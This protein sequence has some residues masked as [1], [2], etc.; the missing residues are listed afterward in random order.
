[1][2]RR[3]FS[4]T[5]LMGGSGLLL[6]GRSVSAAPQPL[7]LAVAS[8]T[9]E[10]NGRAATVFGLTGPD[11]RPGLTLAASETVEVDLE[12][13]LSEE[14]M[15]HWHGLL[16]AW[17]QDGVPDM[18][19]PLLKA[20]ET[21]RYTLP[22]GN[23]GTHWMHAHTLQ[24]QNLLAAPLIVRGPDELARDEQ[25]VVV[26]L[27]DFSFTP[28]EELLA[29]LKSGG[30]MG[31]M[32]NGMNMEGMDHSQ[33]SGMN[34]G[35]GMMGMDVNDIEYDAYLANDR[36]LNDPQVVQV[37]KGGRVRLR[38]ING[39]TATAFTIDTGV[40]VGEVIAVDGQDVVPLKTRQFPLAMGQRVDFRLQLPREGGAFPVFALREGGAQRTGVILA[41]PGAAVGKFLHTRETQGPILSQ[42]IEAGLTAARPLAPKAVDRTYAVNLVG[43]MQGYEW[44]MQSSADLMVRRGERVVIEMRNHSMMTHPMHLHGHHFQIVAINGQDISGAVR[45]TVFLPPMTSIAFSFDAVNPGK[46]WAF[47]CHHL[48]HMA[49]G[50][51]ATV[52]YEGA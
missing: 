14:T 31:M 6:A 33:M 3:D 46:A 29:K 27:H 50:M 45:D 32:M 21:R 1:M 5:L 37:E 7:K 22:A 38:I 15:V 41:T 42:A 43:S 49:T 20:G 25:E 26:L 34:M 24:E 47:H 17:D 28:V 2:N 35:G 36:T 12:N 19:M 51:M 40:L 8:R 39:A 23:P 16:P 9:I 48:Y 18:P 10:V 44:G 4:K 52:G 11:D 13:A 30:G